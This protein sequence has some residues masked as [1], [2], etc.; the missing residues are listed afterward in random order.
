MAGTSNTYQRWYLMRCGLTNQ[1]D[2]LLPEGI[3]KEY[4]ININNDEAIIINEV[5]NK[6]YKRRIEG[7]TA[8]E[9][10]S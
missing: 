3:N 8:K 5:K 7:K 2:K 10:N 4:I 6:T 1:H 9:S